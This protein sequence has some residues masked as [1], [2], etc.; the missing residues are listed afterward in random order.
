MTNQ[1]SVLLLALVPLSCG[2]GE[3]S[4]NG[5]NPSQDAAAES[6]LDAPAET[7]AD[8]AANDTP[9]APPVQS[10]TF[11]ER[12][13]TTI[14]DAGSDHLAFPDVTRLSDG[15]ILLVYRRGNGHVDT[16]GRIMKVFGDAAASTWSD[17]TL[18]HDEPNIDDRDP[19]VTTLHD[20][21]VV[22]NY[23]Q[24]ATHSEGVTLHDSFVGW[25]TDDG[26][27]FSAFEQVGPCPM[28]VQDP[29]VSNDLWVD[30]DDLPIEVWASSSAVIE[31]DGALLL[32]S[33][34]GYALNLSNLAAHPRSRLALFQ[35]SQLGGAWTSV[36]VVPERQP[37]TWLMEPALLLLPDG[38]L[39]MH[40]RT[41]NQASPGSPGN[42]LQASSD[43][44]GSTWSEYKDL[45]FIGHAPELL[46]LRNGVI[47]SAFREINDAYTREWVSMISSLDDGATWSERIQIRDCGASECGYPGLLELDDDALL[48]TY[49]AP[50]GS[51]IDASIYDFAA[52]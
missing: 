14:V 15:R 19:S 5:P 43:D 34:G 17:E 4:P 39:L 22:V 27:T 48:I 52:D 16:S 21:T 40:V 51:S 12:S 35:A 29:K 9:D 11:T 24:Y 50:G 38:T 18:L 30:D 10:I 37:D 46:R 33:Y 2:E 8:D 25:S 31:T 47:V 32:P 6:S 7:A 3:S 1:L 36:P 13:T 49:Y 45:G 44:G 28:G 20:G 41:A 23:F 42:L 26:A